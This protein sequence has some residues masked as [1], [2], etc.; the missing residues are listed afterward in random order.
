[1]KPRGWFAAFLAISLGCAAC[2]A[3]EREDALFTAA[4]KGDARA[5]KELLAQ[6]V[7][8]NARYRYNRTAL[9]F[10]ADRGHLEVVK[11]LLEQGADVN[12]KDTFYGMTPLGQAASNGYMQGLHPDCPEAIRGDEEL[13]V[14]VSRFVSCCCGWLWPA[15]RTGPHFADPRP[16]A[17]RRMP[18]RRFPGTPPGR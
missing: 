14:E 9:S 8:V 2:F 16:V 7:D 13:C 5:V 4:R 11:V 1:M 18:S 3:G 12:T 17:W 6:G 15:R 10:A